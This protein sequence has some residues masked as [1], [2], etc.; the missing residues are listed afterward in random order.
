M[1]IPF[2]VAN[3]KEKLYKQVGKKRSEKLQEVGLSGPDTPKRKEARMDVMYVGVCIRCE[4]KVLLH[5]CLHACTDN[6][7]FI[8]LLT[9]S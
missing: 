5:P 1:L 4:P 2:S 7:D 6:D 8:L 9:I 3:L